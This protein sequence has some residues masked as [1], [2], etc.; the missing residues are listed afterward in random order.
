MPDSIEDSMTTL[1]VFWQVANAMQLL[2]DSNP[3]NPLCLPA[4]G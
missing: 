3:R 2:R 4:E 1:L